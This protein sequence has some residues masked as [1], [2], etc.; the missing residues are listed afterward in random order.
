[1]AEFVTKDSGKRQEFEGGM[2]R[3]TTEGKVNWALV[4][5]GP[6]LKR[7][8][9]LM[10]RGAIK[11]DARNWMKAS[12]QAELDRARESAFRH[13]MQWY[14]GDVD[15]D[16]AAAIL[17]NVNQVEYIKEKSQMAQ[18]IAPQLFRQDVNTK[19]GLG[20]IVGKINGS[21]GPAYAKPEFA[22]GSQVVSQCDHVIHEP[23]TGSGQTKSCGCGLNSFIDLGGLL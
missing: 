23:A 2:V 11:Y 19:R 21:I 4:A 20:N 18:S 17:F 8:A 3:D 13:F 9:E 12:G 15:E 7:W 5:D 16:H 10:T 6:M 1:M 22:T 14:R